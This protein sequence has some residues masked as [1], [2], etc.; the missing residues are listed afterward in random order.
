M[1]IR[2]NQSEIPGTVLE[3]KRWWRREIKSRLAGLND[4]YRHDAAEAMRIR[5]IHSEAYRKAETILFYVSTDKEVMTSEML[6]TALRHGK[7]V[8]LP[9]CVDLDESGRRTCDEPVM[10]ARMFGKGYKLEIGAYGIV[11]PCDD[12][13]L[14]RP[15]EIDLVVLPCVSCD[16]T[17]A[18]L[19]HGGGYYDRFLEDV[20]EDCSKIALCYEEIMTEKLPTEPHD[21]KMDAVITE[22]NLYEKQ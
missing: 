21:I 2:V 6:V 5:L 11:E 17:G 18:R 1:A 9:K 22:E 13:P 20:R 16:I 4:V 3:A 7:R 10:E 14:V 15:E 19:G 8:C 12:A